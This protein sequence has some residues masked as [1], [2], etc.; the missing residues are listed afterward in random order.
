MVKDIYAQ[1]QDKNIRLTSLRKEIIRVFSLSNKPLTILQV[2]IL[3]NKKKCFPHKTS[4]YRHIEQFVDND[5]IQI[6]Q[7][8][9][10]VIYYELQSQHHHHFVCQNCDC[11]LCLDDVHVAALMSTVITSLEK[12]GLIINEHRLSFIGLCKKCQ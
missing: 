12:N 1:L 10:G 2:N 8:R 9:D 7:L 6:V 11:V 3:L 4:L 5:V